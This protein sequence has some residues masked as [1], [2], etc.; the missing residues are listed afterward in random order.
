M[1]VTERGQDVICCLLF[2]LI[3]PDNDYPNIIGPIEMDQ[4][5]N[6]VFMFSVDCPTLA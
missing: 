2:C 6:V 5:D 1:K 3:K 4:N